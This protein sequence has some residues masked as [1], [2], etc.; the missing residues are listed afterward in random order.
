M[1]YHE[2]LNLLRMEGNLNSNRYIHEVL[3]LEVFPFLQGIPGAIFQLDNA[4]PRVAKTVRHFC[5]AQQMHLLPWPAF[6]PDISNIEHVWDLVD[7]LLTRDLRP[8]AS[9]DEFLLPIQAIR[10][11][12]P[13]ADI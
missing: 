2:R 4:R 12:F 7:R 9:K 6:S 10:N 5:S 1:S 8:P 3:Q 11:S 13:Q